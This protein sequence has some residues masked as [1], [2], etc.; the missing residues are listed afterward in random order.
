MYR[1]PV[2]VKDNPHLIPAGKDEGGMKKE[3][4]GGGGGGGEGERRKERGEERVLYCS[5]KL[6]GIAEWNTGMTFDTGMTIDP[7]ENGH[8]FHC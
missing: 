1:L 4:G 3:G 5:T 2:S 6:N 7:H 8:F